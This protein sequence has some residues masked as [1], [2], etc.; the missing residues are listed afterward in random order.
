CLPIK[1]SLADSGANGYV[2]IDSQ[3]AI[4]IA[5]FLNLKIKKLPQKCGTKGFNGTPGTDIT[6]AI[7]LHLWINGRRFLN[8]PMLMTD[9]E[10]HDI[11]IGRLWM[12]E[13]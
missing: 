2:F 11:I 12:E 6:H 3:L 5:K 4:D 1:S 7:Y 9:L 8:V 13:Q 10:R